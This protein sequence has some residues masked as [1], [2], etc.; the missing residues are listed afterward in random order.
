VEHALAD[1]AVDALIFDDEQ[2]GAGAI[3]LGAD[4]PGAASVVSSPG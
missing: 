2:V 4:E 3:G 1:L